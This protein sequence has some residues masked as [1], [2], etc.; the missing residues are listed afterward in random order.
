M[1][2]DERQ[3][4]I[5]RY[6]EGADV[7]AASLAGFPADRLTDHPIAGKWSAAEIVH[8]LSDSEGISAIRVRRLIAEKHAVIHGYDQD[9]YAR[10]LR[11]N[12]R[13]I[14]PALE[15][16]RAV[17]AATVPFLRTLGDDDWTRA[18]WHTES[19]AYTPETWLRIYAAH[20]HG[21]AEQIRRLRE[22]LAGPRG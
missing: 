9:E 18:G 10:A 5:E 20:A 7:V 19:G 15:H 14:T 11:Y 13:D 4:L 2:H 3:R 8:H 1:T 6:A 17:R 21:H 22:A 12:D 16:F